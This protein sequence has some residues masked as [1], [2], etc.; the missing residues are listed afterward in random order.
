MTMERGDDNG[1]APPPLLWDEEYNNGSLA[2]RLFR[3]RVSRDIILFILRF[4]ILRFLV[5]HF[6]IFRFPLVRFR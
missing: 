3:P 2:L 5:L 4:L 1:E 6:L